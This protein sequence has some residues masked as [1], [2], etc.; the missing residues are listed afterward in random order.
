MEDLAWVW[1]KEQGALLQGGLRLI[2]LTWSSTVPALWVF[3]SENS[4]ALNHLALIAVG[5]IGLPLL[6]IRT[7]AADRQ[8]RV[9]NLQAKTAEQGHITDRF[10]K[11]IEQLG[12]EKMA[13]RLG[14][15][16][17]LERLSKDSPGDH[18]TIMEVLTA[19]VRDNAPWPPKQ[20]I[21]GNPFVE[22]QT[23]SENPANHFLHG[24]PA[25]D[26]QAILTVL[27]RRDETAREQELKLDL[28]HANLRRAVLRE[29]HF[30]GANL[31]LTRLE[32]ASLDGAHLERA[33][34]VWRTS[35]VQAWL[36]HTFKVPSCVERIS[37]VPYSLP[38]DFRKPP[39]RKP[40]FL[41]R[42]L[43]AQTSPPQSI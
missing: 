21:I 18:L 10:A 33:F 24:K 31:L 12:S 25:A 3:L 15:I 19:Y 30:E 8:A 11:A 14:A 34:L 28:C 26:I 36:M 42:T 38:R 4:Q 37:K 35:K 22:L 40:T 43:N 41:R 2:L 13:V 16:Y 29:A 23:N 20:E 6:W 39:S 27:G 9:A 17:A 7:R 32:G 1:V 5:A